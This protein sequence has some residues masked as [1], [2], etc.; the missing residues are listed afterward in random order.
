M[1]DNKIKALEIQVEC[2]EFENKGEKIEYTTFYVLISGIKVKIQASDATG[3]QLLK[4]H[5]GV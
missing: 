4:A 2:G 1:A 3:K 5:Y